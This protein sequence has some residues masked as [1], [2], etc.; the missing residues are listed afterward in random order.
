MGHTRLGDLPKT[1]R[2]I[3]VAA[4][5]DE[6][7]DPETIASETLAA[8]E[9]GF[10]QATQDSG[11]KYAFWLLTQ[12]TLAAREANFSQELN[13]LGL[14]VPQKAGLF[15]VISSFTMNIDSYLQK[16]R[17]RSDISEM[18]Q[19]AAVETLS[20]K[21]VELCRGL[22]STT[23]EDVRHAVQKLSTK[24]NFALLAR[25][26]FS[27]FTYRYLN[28]FLSRETSKH[29]GPN[30]SFANIDE[31]TAFNEALAVHCKQTAVIV[32]DFAG[33]W[34]SKTAYE[35]GITPQDAEGFTAVALK[36]LLSE[37]KRGA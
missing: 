3:Q 25:D 20:E 2:W 12:V 5:L 36:K 15:D 13:K 21:C 30:Q 14:D 37:L 23:S 27:R 26:F 34:Y 32:Q 31:H 8:A 17:A 18:A 19:L 28:Y 1:R 6:G 35:T 4:L 29:V 11:F 9:T 7:A 22:F 16:A 33:G 24:K 10:T